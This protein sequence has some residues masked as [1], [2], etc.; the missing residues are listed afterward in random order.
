VKLRHRI[1]L[2][3]GAICMTAPALAVSSQAFPPYPHEVGGRSETVSITIRSLEQNLRSFS[4]LT[5]QALRD[6]APQQRSVTETPG[7]PH[8]HS[9]NPMLDGL[10]AMAVSDARLN[11]VSA[12][13]D[14]AYNAGEPIPCDCFQTG[15]SWNY[16]WTRDVSYAAHLGLAWFD[17]QRVVNSLLFKTSGFRAGTAPVDGLR[18]D[19][20][21]IVQDTGSGG[22]WPVSTDRV[23]WAWGAAAAL[24]VLPAAERSAFAERALAALRGTL[25]ADRLAAFDARSGL[26]GGEQS[27]LDWRTQSYAPWI[28]DKLSS[29][30]ASK[31]LST[32]VS[33]WQALSLAAQLAGERQDVATAERYRGWADALK[34]SINR[35]FWL[36]DVKRYASVT[37]DDQR[38]RALHQFDLLGTAL[39]IITG[40]APPQR[41]AEALARYPHAPFGAPVI[42]PQQ[43]DVYVYHN[44]AIWPFVSAYALRAA[45]TTRN[46]AVA[47]HALESLTRAAALNLSNM[48]NL[49]WLSAKPRHD[50]GPAINS[51]RQLWSVAAQL[52]VL[53]ESVFGFKP[54]PDGLR[55]DPFL[56]LTARR[57]LGAGKQASLE[58]LRY[59][60]MALSITLRLPKL[61]VNANAQ[62]WYPLNRVTLNG[63]ALAG[64]LIRAGQL[65][66]GHNRIELTFGALRQEGAGIT[67][68]ADGVDSLSHG[69]PRVFA[70]RLPR[71]AGLT[72]DAASG[73]VTVRMEPAPMGASPAPQLQIY[74]D[75]QLV[76]RDVAALSW[77]DPQPVR[78]EQRR[79]YSAEA[80]DPAN[81]HHSQPSAPAC[82]ESATVQL[83]AVTDP[84]VRSNVPVT[85]PGD[86]LALATLRDWGQPGDTLSVNGIAL[87]SAGRYGIELLYNN[88]AND[89]ST[90]ITNAVKRLR[91]L[92]SDGA[93]VASG[94]IQMP[95]VD[96]RDG[97]HP[98]RSSTLLTLDLPAGTY[99]LELQDFFNMSYLSAN[100]SYS[101]AGGKGGPVNRASIAAFKV[102]AIE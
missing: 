57:A 37:T 31:S 64:T 11:S 67:R 23:T 101:G 44:R 19:W 43:P 3:A 45:A 7:D 72:H 41:A 28:V 85:P 5:T 98:I 96:P 97:G 1:D 18:P 55:L 69:D 39:V 73:R 36:D 100:S 50:D 14:S 80:V 49:E 91:V 87:P 34:A 16:V 48:E 79:C 52:S 9:G 61:P 66:G 78:G 17:P 25:E 58:N 6:Q 56:T 94:V 46:A 82:F 84:R 24:D 88:H 74:R 83:V 27:F 95:H 62:G 8:L 51:R 89:I 70:P 53:A 40:I 42:E 33:H 81:G 4:F 76:A 92:T 77:T 68:I 102:F 75:G 15:E 26:Y 2:N 12:I 29:L 30:S 38:P 22:S 32:N 35:V 21:Q 13:R 99:T 93:E 20:T 47:G 10:F 65:K 90:G 86:G 63:H 59:Q 54:G 60:G 71:I